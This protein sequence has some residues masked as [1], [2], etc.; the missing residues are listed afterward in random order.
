MTGYDDHKWLYWLYVIEFATLNSQKAVNATL[1]AEGY[2]QGGLGN[3]V[4]DANSTEWSNFNSY[5]PFVNCGA[6]DSLA[7]GTGE[8]S[9]TITNFGG[10][11]V[12]RLF[13]VP[14]YRGIENPFGHIWKWID[15]ANIEAQAVA[16]GNETR[17]WVSESVAAWNDSNYTGYT[18]RGLLARADGY[19]SK[20]L[21][22][23]K[24]DIMPAISSGSSTTY[25]CDYAYQNV[26]AS[27]S[28]LRGLLVGGDAHNG[29][30]D[31]FVCSHMD[32]APSYAGT[33][34]G[35]RLRF[36]AV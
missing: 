36:K 29:V 12:N 31:G 17:L 13:K 16:S 7:N 32:Y 20:A 1:T 18:N 26:P 14:R 6:S 34:V 30:K 10:T 5:N 35:A 4:S 23:T 3:G 15:G 33:A 2:K 22:G 11:G 28:A 21:M 24:A 27:G 25:Y 19:M 8:V 9:V